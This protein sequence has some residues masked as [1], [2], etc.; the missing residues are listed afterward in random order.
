MATHTRIPSIVV[1]LDPPTPRVDFMIVDAARYLP[2]RRQARL[3]ETDAPRIAE[4]TLG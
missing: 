1:V 2:C 3:G 4:A